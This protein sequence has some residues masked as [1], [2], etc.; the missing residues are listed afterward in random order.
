MVQQACS[1]APTAENTITHTAPLKTQR[2][3]IAQKL[4]CTVCVQY[5]VC[6]KD[7]TF[8]NATFID[9]IQMF[10]EIQEHVS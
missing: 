6:N 8:S 1:Q 7:I 5:T 10:T 3:K 2:H 4:K 9:S